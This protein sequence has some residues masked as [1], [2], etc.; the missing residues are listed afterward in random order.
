MDKSEKLMREVAKQLGKTYEEYDREL[1]NAILVSIYGGIA[2]DCSN[3]EGKEK[4]VGGLNTP[5]DE[6]VEGN[7]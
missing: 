7:K 4:F 3:A 6:C 5:L 1:T 2:Y